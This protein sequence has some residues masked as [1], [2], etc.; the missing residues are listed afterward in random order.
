MARPADTPENVEAA[1]D[2]GAAVGS[3]LRLPKLSHLVAGRLRDQIVSGK[4]KPGSLLM[5][6]NQLLAIFKVSRPTL[7]EALRI[8]EAEAL[9]NIGR[10]M[11]SGAVV[12]GPSMQKAAEFATFMLISEGVTMNELHEA[13]MFFEPEV[14]RSLKGSTLKQTIVQLREC[15]S[16]LNEALE[17]RRYADVVAGTNRFHEVLARSSG[18]RPIALMIGMLQMISDDAYAAILT[19]GGGPEDAVSANMSKSILGYSALCDLLDKGK[20]PEAAAFWRRYMERGLEFLKRSKLG[21]R[22]LVVGGSEA[23]NAQQMPS[24][25]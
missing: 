6:E 3:D 23:G 17:E 21:E 8:L 11:R 16:A 22:R 19:D 18:N 10:G 14:I 5:P 1:Y 12:L 20:L 25:S 4:L 24:K 7:R 2:L 13:R 15:I 9:I